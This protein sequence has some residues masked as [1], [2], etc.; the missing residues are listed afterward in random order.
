VSGLDRDKAREVLTARLPRDPKWD[1]WI[2]GALDALEE[3][4]TEDPR[5][6]DVRRETVKAVLDRLGELDR[7][8]YTDPDE[9]VY[10]EFGVES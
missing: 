3:C 1:V 8:G 10:R 4:V 9:I 6:D 5:I 2:D 7:Q